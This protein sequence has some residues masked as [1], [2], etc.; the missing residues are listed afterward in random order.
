M[1]KRIYFNSKE[2]RDLF[3]KKVLECFNTLN[4]KEIRDKFN[5]PKSTFEFYKNGRFTLPEELYLILSKKFSKEDKLFF[6]SKTN[7]LNSNWGSVKAGKITYSKHK[8]IF[9]EGRKLAIKRIQAKVNKFDINLTLTKK[10][11]YFIGLFIGDGFT[12]TYQRY[13]LI[14]FTGDKRTE[15]GYYEILIS[16]YSKQLFNLTPI[17]REEKKSNGL[18]FNLYS[19]QLFNLITKRFKISAGRKSQ[20]VLIPEEILKSK[21]EILKACIRGIY[22]AEGCVFFD[23]R[24]SYTK[25]YLRIDLHMNNAGILKQICNILCDFGIKGSLVTIPNNQR[26]IVYGEK[27]TKKFIKEIGF[28]N[29]KHLERLKNLNV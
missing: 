20:T 3:F 26:V 1:D 23:K 22:D 27:Q 4:W 9:D 13:Y 12:N 29:P 25:P 17:I 21:P 18:R 5:I 10:L 6:M 14:Q 2:F 16:K 8:N 7:V 11:A 24:K 15:R 19:K 28:S